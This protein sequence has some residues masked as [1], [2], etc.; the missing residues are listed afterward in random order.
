MA[1]RR[2]ASSEARVRALEALRLMRTES[3]SRVQAA[4]KAGTTPRTMARYVG[5]ALHRPRDGHY[6]AKPTDRLARP[7]FVLT[8]E[9]LKPLVPHGS[10]VTSLVAKHW[11]AVQRFLATGE[12]DV[13]RRFHGKRVA[14]YELETDPDVIEREGHRGALEFEDL[15]ES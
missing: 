15:Y 13:L 12:E 9:G 4:G 2:S 14:G 6:V 5:P 3:L 10:R 7:V 11:N 1:E 8:K